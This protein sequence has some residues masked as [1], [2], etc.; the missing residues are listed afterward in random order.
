M[1]LFE[2]VFIFNVAV[3]RKLIST[4]FKFQCFVQVYIRAI[5]NSSLRDNSQNF[6][7]VNNRYIFE[8][9]DKNYLAKKTNPK[10]LKT[11]SKTVKSER[12][13]LEMFYE[14]KNRQIFTFHM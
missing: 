4:R 2:K 1:F 10:N 7:L 12:I 5:Q 6:L 3:F 8:I 14:K 13:L 11:T 9:P